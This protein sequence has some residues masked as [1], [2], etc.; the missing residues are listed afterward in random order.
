MKQKI[1][2]VTAWIIFKGKRNSVFRSK[3]SQ[4]KKLQK[5]ENDDE[6]HNYVISAF[7]CPLLWAT[8]VSTVSNTRSYI[9]TR[10]FTRM[11]NLNSL[12]PWKS[13]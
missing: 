12:Y 13:A 2:A 3:L 10:I 9:L 11:K 5:S 1:A 8:L 6:S 7:S 4:E